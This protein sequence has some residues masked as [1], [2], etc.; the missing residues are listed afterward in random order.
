MC[1]FAALTRT[2]AK[3]GAKFM[4]G[5]SRPRALVGFARGAVIAAALF[6]AACSE[7]S[8][9]VNQG[10]RYDRL[11]GQIAQFQSNPA[12][13]GFLAEEAARAGVRSFRL[14]NSTRNYGRANSDG[15]IELSS[16]LAGGTGV[17]NVTH[18]I[19]HVAGFRRGCNGHTRCWIVNYLAIAKRYEERF[20]GERWSGTTPTKRVLRNVERFRIRM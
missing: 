14:I 19:A 12:K 1:M 18:E 5:F 17:I 11:S 15:L 8:T 4:T 10:S 13:V 3:S 16:A 7:T 6:L 2:G 20:P 9:Q